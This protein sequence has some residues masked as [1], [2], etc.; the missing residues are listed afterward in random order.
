M[1]IF[2]R[3]SRRKSKL[4]KVSHET[5]QNIVGPENT[6]MDTI[7]SKQLVRFGYLNRMTKNRKPK[8]DFVGFQVENRKDKDQSIDEEMPLMKR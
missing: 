5:I 7:K 8:K 6:I 3:R 1:K 4:E 2:W